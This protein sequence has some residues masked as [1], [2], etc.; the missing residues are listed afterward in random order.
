MQAS[1]FFGVFPMPVARLGLLP[2]VILG[3]ALAFAGWSVGQGVERFR[4]ADRTV[5]VK[6]LAGMDVKSEF[7]IWTLAF[8]RGGNAFDGVRG[9]RSADRG[10][11]GASRA[12][13]RINP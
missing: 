8:R 5:T 6:G 10:Q 4:M 3:A 11:G 13:Q 2:A 9:E 7:A 12:A 1:S